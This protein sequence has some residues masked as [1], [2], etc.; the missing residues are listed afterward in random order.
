MMMV[1]MMIM[2]M[3]S[4]TFAES[5][6]S[7][8]MYM[9]NTTV[10]MREMSLKN[11]VN[12]LRSANCDTFKMCSEC[13]SAKTW[14]GSNCRWCPKTGDCHAEGSLSN[15]CS[16]DEQITDKSNCP[17]GPPDAPSQ[18]HIAFNGEKG[19]TISWSTKIKTNS[20]IVMY[21]TSEAK[22]SMKAN[23]VSKQLLDN[24]YHHVSLDNLERDMTYYYTCG[25]GDTDSDV[26]SFRT[27][28]ET[29]SGFVVSVFG[30]WGYGEN[31]H[32]V[33]TRN[34]LDTIT[35]NVNF[36]WHLGDIAYADDAF[37]HDITGFE[38][39]NIYDAW[40]NW[41]QNISAFKPYMVSPG[42]HESECHAPSCITSKTYREALQNFSAFNTRW[43]MPFEK[44]SSR[45]NMWY[46]YNYGLAHFVSTNT[47][48]DFPGMTT[49][50]SLS[51][52]FSSKKNL[53]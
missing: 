29:S 22:L 1:M 12:L 27:A 36:V 20:T 52:F 37:L 50:V 5:T 2:M 17:T 21:G 47:E 46:S 30:D 19:M 11:D 45:S 41:I 53:Y 49:F 8:M 33:A 7:Q 34:A 23:G 28:P 42:N 13:A 16:T 10:L 3:M 15:K 39:E 4:A 32:A 48:T 14:T 6:M 40:M 9:G 44:S 38:Y 31:G 35:K 24:Y 43:D 18:I 51:L 25:D 26:Y